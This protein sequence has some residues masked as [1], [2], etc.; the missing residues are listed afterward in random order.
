MDCGPYDVI[1]GVGGGSEV[2]FHFLFVSNKGECQLSGN[3]NIVP[4]QSF[5]IHTLRVLEGGGPRSIFTFLLFLIEED[6]SYQEL[7]PE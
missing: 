6:G 7:F 2:E 4:S 5:E 3:K 1:S